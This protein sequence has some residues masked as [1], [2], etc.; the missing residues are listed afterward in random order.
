MIGDSDTVKGLYQM[1]I[2]LTFPFAREHH[3]GYV[4]AIVRRSASLD[5]YH[6]I[7]SLTLYKAFSFRDDLT[8][9]NVPRHRRL[10]VARQRRSIGAPTLSRDPFTY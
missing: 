10:H 7:I 2:C 8:T 3:I 1:T 5:N 4:R 6:I 9:R